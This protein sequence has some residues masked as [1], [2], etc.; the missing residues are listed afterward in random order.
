M[1]A[2]TPNGM[3]R[4]SDGE[5]LRN[6][7]RLHRAGARAIRLDLT[8]ARIE[9]PGPPLRDYEFGEY[10]RE[11]RAIRRAGLKVIGLLA[12]GHPDYSR[13]G[14]AAVAAGAGGGLPPFGV[15]AAHLYPPDDPADFA[16]YAAATAR[17][18]GREVIAWEVWNEQNEGWRFW[19]PREDP[20][21]YGRLL[22]AAHDA[23]RAVDPRTPVLFGGVFYPG[24]T[25]GLPGMSGPQFVR[26]AYSANP[27]LGRCYEILAYHPYPYPFTAPEARVPIRGSVPDARRGMLEA[28]PIEERGSTPVW[29]TEVGW[30]T[31]RAYGVSEAKQAQYLARTLALTFAQGTGVANLYTY[32]D[33]PDPSQ[34]MNQ[35]A[36]FGVI[37]ADGSAKP[38]LAAVRTLHRM[39]RGTRYRRNVAARL[40]MPN[41]SEGLGGYS[42]EQGSE[43]FALRFAGPRRQ[44]TMI[45][46]ANESAIEE[47]G[48]D[49]LRGGTLAG[50]EVEV[51]LPVRR[52]EVV[53]VDHLG[54]RTRVRA[55]ARTVKVNASPAPLYVIERR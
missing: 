8:W 23:L 38:A 41:G 52:R 5:M 9:P 13:A 28:L 26:S 47:Q 35:E 44:V 54:K 45:W 15:G 37:R 34:G 27:D 29:V 33:E 22:C 21:A 24:V 43:G 7:R 19:P 42:I 39:L 14:A 11:I 10:D 46:H 51:S 12:Y 30:P 32:G 48:R 18:F 31:H 49:G 2:F 4:A 53:V 6:Y 55:R 16:R 40:G 50:G 20:A 25:P 3:P 17:H 1:I 36:H